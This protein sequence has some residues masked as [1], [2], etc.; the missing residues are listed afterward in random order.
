MRLQAAFSDQAE[1]HDEHLADHEGAEPEEG[2]VGEAIG[3]ETDTEHVGAEPGP[4]GDDVAEDGHDH[5][6]ALAD[7]AAPAGVEDDGVPNDD[8]Q[9]AVF[10]GVPAPEAAPRLVGPDATEHGA[11]EAG[12]G[13]ETDHAVDHAAQRGGGGFRDISEGA[14][15]QID[16]GDGAGEEGGRVAEGDDD[17]M[18]GEPEIRIEHGAHHFQGIA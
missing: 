6:P 3:M 13:G 2:G 15:D 12:E 9:G 1:H 8:E 18:G 11:D 14:A 7:H 16:G 5:H 10:L 17:D 4:T